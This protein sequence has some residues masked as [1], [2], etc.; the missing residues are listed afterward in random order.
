MAAVGVTAKPETIRRAWH[1]V[2]ADVARHGYSKPPTPQ[3]SHEDETRP[4]LRP[5]EVAP[6]V[7]PVLSERGEVEAEP[8]QPKRRFRRGATFRGTEE[9]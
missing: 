5:G 7:R 1:R 6:G 3:K 9:G 8:E 2:E 4:P